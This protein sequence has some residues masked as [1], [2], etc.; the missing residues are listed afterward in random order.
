MHKAS[1]VALFLLIHAIPSVQ[2]GVE[3]TLFGP[4][5]FTRTGG[6]PNVFHASFAAASGEGT[7]VVTNGSSSGN[8][9]VS[10][11]SIW[12]NGAEIVGA[13]GFGQSVSQLTIPVDL[14]PENSIS[15][16]L[17]SA[18]GSF[19]SISV[20]QV[21]EAQWIAFVEGNPGVPNDGV[22]VDGNAGSLS[23][24]LELGAPIPLNQFANGFTATFYPEPLLNDSP[25]TLS[26]QLNIGPTEECSVGFTMPYQGTVFYDGVK[27]YFRNYPISDLQ[28]W[29]VD[30]INTY[31]PQCNAT[32]DNLFLY[33]IVI[34]DISGPPQRLFPLLDAF[35]LR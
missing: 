8:C 34:V 27:G 26:I 31:N 2:A 18:P 20:V 6:K 28:Y 15:I 29:V 19:L 14:D 30:D 35:E 24:F 5:Q 22:F 12:I 11:A 1:C 3:M 17:H 9:R 7:L 16:E 10:S 13:N 21:V 23:G 33:Y 32:V 4:V 25:E